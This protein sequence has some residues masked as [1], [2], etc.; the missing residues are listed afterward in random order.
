MTGRYFVG[1]Q[2]SR[3]SP[4]SYDE[5]LQHRLWE[6][7]ARLMALADARHTLTGR[8]ARRISGMPIYAYRC[9]A[10]DA[11]FEQLVRAETTVACPGCKSRKLERLMSLHRPAGRLPA[12]PPTSAVS[13]PRPAAGAAAADVT[14]TPTEPAARPAGRAARRSAAGG[15]VRMTRRSSGRRW[16]WCWCRRPMPFCSSAAPS[17]PAIRGRATWRSRVVARSRATPTCSARPSVRPSRR[18]GSPSTATQLV[19]SLDDVIPRT[20]V[21]PPIAVR[22]FVFSL[23]DRPSLSPQPRGR[24]GGLGR[25][26]IICSGRRPITRP[27]S[28]SAARPAT[29]RPTGSRTRSSGE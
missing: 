8:A 13:V 22:P 27:G 28:T 1:R 19:G 26:S 18:S 24:R 15:T 16:P 4:A 3:S 21:L 7:S 25:R 23:P 11:Q 29:C 6:E 10:C 5:R 12:S 20:P 17:G 9:A 2:E 14:R